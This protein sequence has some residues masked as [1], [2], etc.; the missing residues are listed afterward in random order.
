MASHEETVVVS[1]RMPKALAEKAESFARKLA[2]T[3]DRRLTRT[4]LI[5]EILEQG[6]HALEEEE[7]TN[8][9]VL[10]LAD[11]GDF[12]DGNPVKARNGL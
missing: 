4:R 9:A 1:V 11:T 8:R 7:A 2:Y 6:L 3:Q 10:A 12:E 5:V